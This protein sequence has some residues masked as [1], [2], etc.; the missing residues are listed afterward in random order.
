MIVRGAHAV[1]HG[2]PP[3]FDAG[4]GMQRD[5]FLIERADPRAALDEIVALVVRA[6][7]RALR[8]RPGRPTSRSSRPCTAARWG[9]TR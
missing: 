9:S 4:D 8:G 2:E 6:A 3:S 1:R 5:L 7:A